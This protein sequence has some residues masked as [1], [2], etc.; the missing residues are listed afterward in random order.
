[1][2]FIEIALVFIEAAFVFIE[3]AFVFIE[4]GLIPCHS[5]LFSLKVFQKSNTFTWF[6]YQNY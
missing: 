2:V 5:S 3:V 1:M 6:T 4:A